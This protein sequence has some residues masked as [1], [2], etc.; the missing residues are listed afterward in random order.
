VAKKLFPVE[1]QFHGVSV[2]EL[3]IRYGIKPHPKG[4]HT[5]ICCVKRMLCFPCRLVSGKRFSSI[6][7]RDC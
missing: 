4:N 5:L 7:I 1:E 6:K 2:T 3:E